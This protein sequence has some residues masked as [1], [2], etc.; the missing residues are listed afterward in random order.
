MIVRSAAIVSPAQRRSL[1]VRIWKYRYHYVAISPFYIV[2]LVFGFYPLVYTLY[3]SFYDWSGAAAPRLVGLSNYAALFTNGPF[4]AA[5]FNSLYYLVLGVPALVIGSLLSAV[6]LNNRRLGLRAIYRTLFFLPYVTSEIIVAI[7]FVAVFDRQFGLI[8]GL[9]QLLSIGPVPWLVSTEW[10]KISVLI[11]FVW[12]RMG[13]YLILM[14]AG[15]QSIPQELYEAAS[16]DGASGTQSFFRITVP[17]MQGIILFVLITTTIAVLNMFGAPYVLTG[18]G[19]QESST[20]LTLL[21]YRTAF[22]WVNYGFACSIAVVISL[23]S[24]VIALVQIKL[25]GSH[26]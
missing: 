7:V 25:L 3:L 19:P 13:Y 21:L 14:L 8:N 26:E 16:I 9:L 4:Q 20:S 18:G 2:F 24:V 22:Q 15:L 11:L 5:L 12:A 17:M 1:A 6:I 23:I 10:S